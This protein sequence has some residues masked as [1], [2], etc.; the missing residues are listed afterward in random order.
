MIEHA[1]DLAE[2]RWI[3]QTLGLQPS[4]DSPLLDPLSSVPE[5]PKGSPAEEKVVKR[6]QARGLATRE[7][8]PNPFAAAALTWLASP[9]KVWCLSLFGPGGAEL[10]HL[11]FRE[12]SAVECRR[13]ASGVRLRYPLPE[14]DALAWLSL[15]TGGGGRAR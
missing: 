9:Q 7:G 5:V 13:D 14:E 15:R 6:L 8:S 10:V 2:A 1:L 3:L 4:G 12:G 11:A